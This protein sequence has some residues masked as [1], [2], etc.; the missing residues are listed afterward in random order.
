MEQLL[1]TMSRT[2]STGTNHDGPRG[3]LVTSNFPPSFFGS[4]NKNS[5]DVS[6]QHS[7]KQLSRESE[8]SR[9]SKRPKRLDAIFKSLSVRANRPFSVSVERDPS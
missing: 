3:P 4:R 5:G 8:D 9:R 6:S 1:Q 7:K 2:S